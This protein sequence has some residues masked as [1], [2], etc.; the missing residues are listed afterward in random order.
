LISLIALIWFLKH[1]SLRYGGFSIIAL[2]F[3]LPLSFALETFNTSLGRKKKTVI[4]LVLISLLIFEARN[5]N[6]IKKEI[7]VYNFDL[8]NAPFGFIKEV[9]SENI[10]KNNI[11][12]YNPINDMCWATKSPCTYRKDLKVKENL[13]IRFFINRFRFFY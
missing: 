7:I 8:L 12:I 9:K 5:I 11:E 10:S 13:A 4:A 3:F 1:P 2:I 6:R